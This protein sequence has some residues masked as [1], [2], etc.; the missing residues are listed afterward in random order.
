MQSLS[1]KIVSIF[2]RWELVLCSHFVI[3]FYS[4]RWAS[5]KSIDF[6]D[7]RDHREDLKYVLRSKGVASVWSGIYADW[8]EYECE[9]NY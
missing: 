4:V 1:Q 2:F 9:G 3:L 7:L 8:W 5:C 6:Y